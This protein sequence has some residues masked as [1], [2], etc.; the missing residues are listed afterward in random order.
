MLAEILVLG[1]FPAAMAFAAASDLI[2]MTISNR[3]SLAL[4]AAFFL[5]AVAVGMPVADMGRHVLASLVVLAVAFAFFAR[6]W[7]GGGDAK[8]PAAPP[9]WL[10]LP[11]LVGY[12]LG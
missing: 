4:C 3:L 10:R 8:L 5:V 9:P 12:P 6:G 7:I 1:L 11:P 2:T